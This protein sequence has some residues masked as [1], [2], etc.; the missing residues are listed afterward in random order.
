[1]FWTPSR[2]KPLVV[3]LLVKYQDSILVLKQSAF[4][5]GITRPSFTLYQLDSTASTVHTTSFITRCKISKP[6][7]SQTYHIDH[8][9]VPLPVH[10]SGCRVHRYMSMFVCSKVFPWVRRLEEGSLRVFLKGARKY[11]R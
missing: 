6:D 8:T 7:P 4:S 5:L 3:Y 10:N 1:M 2:R 9:A 11:K